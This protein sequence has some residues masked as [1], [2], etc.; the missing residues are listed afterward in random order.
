MAASDEEEVPL[1]VKERAR[2]LNSRPA[3]RL[4]LAKRT[5]SAPSREEIVH[6]L[7]ERT[8]SLRPNLS[9]FGARSEDLLRATKSG[10]VD[11]AGK[12]RTGFLEATGS[13]KDFIA[14]PRSAD[15]RAAPSSLEDGT[16]PFP[17]F[18]DEPDQS[19]EISLVDSSTED[20]NERLSPRSAQRGPKW[21]LPDF[22][23][24]AVGLA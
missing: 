16:V 1:S 24:Q 2:I 23:R 15:G 13:I 10:V 14:R 19:Q 4:G 11:I 12:G 21:K 8:H 5:K 20:G 22:D 7:P 17:A 6:P 3:D 9:Q 18:E